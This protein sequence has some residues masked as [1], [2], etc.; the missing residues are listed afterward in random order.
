MPIELT[1][2]GPSTRQAFY[3][4]LL[5]FWDQRWEGE[6]E[7]DFLDWRYA[8]RTDG[9]TLVA[10]SG[11]RCLGLLDSFLRPYRLGDCRVMVREPCDWYCLPGSRGVGMRLMKSLMAQQEPLL[12]VG[13]PKAALA[14]A[15]RL[16]WR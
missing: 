3:D 4:T 16:K 7:R 8:R 14:I 6:F 9:E 13:L 15:P 2:V 10:M 1:K 11:G 5:T 12:G